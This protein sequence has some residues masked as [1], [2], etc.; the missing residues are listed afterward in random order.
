[1]LS[2]AQIPETIS[3]Q[4]LLKDLSKEIRHAERFLIALNPPKPER[5]SKRKKKKPVNKDFVDF[6][7]ADRVSD[8]SKIKSPTKEQ[9]A[10]KE[11]MLHSKG[12]TNRP[13]LKL[14]LPKP[15]TI[16]QTKIGD[17]VND[18]SNSNVPIPVK[19]IK[20][21]SPKAP[22]IKK[23]N[24]NKTTNTSKISNIKKVPNTK[25]NSN[26]KKPNENKKLSKPRKQSPTVIRF[27]LGD[28]EVVRRTKDKGNNIYGNFTLDHAVETRKELTWKQ[29]TSVYDFHDGSNES[30]YSGFT[31]DE[32][33][34]KKKVQ[35]SVNNIKKLKAKLY[36]NEL[37]KS[38]N[39]PKNGIE[40]LLKAS[41]YT[42][43]TTVASKI[44]VT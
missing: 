21:L 16:P 34:K 30:D 36:S 38:N 41:V 27:K 15:S 42:L 32:A 31:I 20:T 19:K 26:I 8:T 6:K 33:P 17:A 14:T 9:L 1:M 2:R 29:T 24:T 25:K 18:L 40:E 22:T 23:S 39:T 7:I 10:K 37:E 3:S 28:K 43:S 11:A 4:K 13:P 35:K 5:E 12:L 44:D